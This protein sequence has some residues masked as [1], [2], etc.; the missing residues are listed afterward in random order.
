MK[1]NLGKMLIVIIYFVVL[2]RI[3][4]GN[5]EIK[6]KITIKTIKDIL[7]INENFNYQISAKKIKMMIMNINVLEKLANK[8]Q[9]VKDSNI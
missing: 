5:K 6:H 8:L 1:Q 7:E 9:I 3:F 2:L 4:F